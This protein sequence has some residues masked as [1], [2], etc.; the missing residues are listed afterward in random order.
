MPTAKFYASLIV[1]LSLLTSLRVAAAPA[2]DKREIRARADFAA[3]RY[4]TALDTF[5]ELFS[6]NPD[7]VFLR[8]IARCHQKLEQ[9]KLAIDRFREYLGKS[10]GLARDE[11]TEIE[12]YIK[13][14]EAMDA[15]QRAASAS[16]EAP[17][18][19]S[20]TVTPPPTSSP[21]PAPVAETQP[22]LVQQPHETT[23]LEGKAGS[24]T[25]GRAWRT[26]GIATAGGGAVLLGMGLVFGLSAQSAAD[27]VSEKYDP[28][29]ER[30]GKRAVTL[31]WVSYGVGAAAVTAG[32][33]MYLH[34]RERGRTLVQAKS[35][36]AAAVMTDGGGAMIFQGTF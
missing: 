8:N 16:A 5:V 17:P 29:T 31:Q 25:G 30:D 20:G 26:A 12:G 7:P 22:Q 18:P 2:S 28:E 36:R 6:E 21:V 10:Q 23:T 34:G 14:M 27:E 3:G 4:Q 15:A 9:P 19:F 11:R 33:L 32:I 35:F 13:E 24:S 1:V